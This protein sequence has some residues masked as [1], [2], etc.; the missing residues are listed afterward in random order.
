MKQYWNEHNF[1][2]RVIS[3][4]FGGINFQKGKLLSVKGD[5]IKP[6]YLFH[7]MVLYSETDF[8]LEYNYLATYD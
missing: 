8:I 5:S 1:H 6:L 2:K 3:F 7:C 4:L